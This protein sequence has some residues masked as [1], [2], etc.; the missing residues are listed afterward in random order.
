MSGP[1]ALLVLGVL[2]LVGGFVAGAVARAALSLYR[3]PRLG[4]AASTVCGIVGATAGAACVAL[5]LGRPAR[6]APAG[7][8]LGGVAGTIIVLL[9]ADLIA[10]ARAEPPARA[11]ELI[12]AGESDRV[13]FKSSARYNLHT[14]V[15]DA[16]LELV[17]ATAVA[18]FLNAKGGSLLI[19]V[20]DDGSVLGLVND[21][22]LLRRPDRDSYELWLR[23]LLA[24]TLGAPAAQSVEVRFESITDEDVCVVR[25][26]PFR[27]PVFL[28]QPKQRRSE[29]VVRVGNSTRQLDARDTVA[30]AA[31]HWSRRVLVRRAALRR[32]LRSSAAVQVTEP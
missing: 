29:F 25:V 13:E 14:H 30:Y 12:S 1:A 5:L 19:G 24:T 23:D 2:V 27:S 21:Y 28:T 11:A 16:R 20:S 26:P 22:E 3:P 17:I 4:W 15:R 31:A 8:V 32:E 10:A 6:S 7:V 9:A 18:G